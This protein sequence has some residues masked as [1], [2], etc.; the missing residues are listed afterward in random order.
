MSVTASNSRIVEVIQSELVEQHYASITNSMKRTAVAILHTAQCVFEAKKQLNRTSFQALAEKFGSASL[1]SK[2]LTIGERA[3]ALMI[4]VDVLPAS[5]TSLYHLSRLPD[6]KFNEY[7]AAKQIHASMTNASAA[8]LLNTPPPSASTNLAYVIIKSD[9]KTRQA[10]QDNPDK[11]ASLLQQLSSLAASFKS[12]GVTV[13]DEIP[14]C[15]VQP[16]RKNPRFG[17]S[18]STTMSSSATQ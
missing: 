5:R 12:L 9:D 10:Q 16:P 3:G 2:L 14:Q 4:H 13:K 15:Q 7:L 1:L 17:R 18:V 6:D 11:M 8:K